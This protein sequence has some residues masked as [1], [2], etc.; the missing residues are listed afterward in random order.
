MA[1]V[2][3]FHSYK[4]KEGVSIPDYLLAMETLIKEFVS[5]QKGFISFKHLH[6]R[7]TETWADFLV[8]ET[9]D[10][11]N[12]FVSICGKNE[13][14]RK[15]FALGGSYDI[16]SYVFTVEQSFWSCKD[17]SISIFKLIRQQCDSTW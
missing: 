1:N 6:D 16:K 4:L 2:V 13:L 17:D 12:A 7:E 11:L 9:M 5:E 14:A 8:F 15:L 10:D 3:S